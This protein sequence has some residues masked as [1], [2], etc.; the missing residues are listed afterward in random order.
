MCAARMFELAIFFCS[1]ERL[2]LVLLSRG[3]RR[4]LERGVE[5]VGAPHARG[6]IGCNVRC[7]VVRNT[8]C[9]DGH[10]ANLGRGL[11]G[12]SVGRRLRRRLLMRT[13][14]KCE[15]NR[16]REC[17]PHGNLHSTTGECIA[18]AAQTHPRARD[19]VQVSAR[20]VEAER[21]KRRRVGAE[22]TQREPR[23][24]VWRVR[25]SEQPGAL[26]AQPREERIVRP[27]S[28]V[29]SSATNRAASSHRDVSTAT[30]GHKRWH[31]LPRTNDVRLQR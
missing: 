15:S 14:G 29:R 19:R 17:L 13:T 23:T 1:N 2:D 27:R 26:R 30:R 22:V 8:P 31:F 3:Q 11:I 6:R 28:K 24:R 25:I 12:A 18:R 7:P 16:D 5:D 10:G 20:H 21:H 9:R 4:E